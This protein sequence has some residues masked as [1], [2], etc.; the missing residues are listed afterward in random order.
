MN[1]KIAK[2]EVEAIINFQVRLRQVEED[3]F[4]EI[5]SEEKNSFN[6]DRTVNSRQ[7]HK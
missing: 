4:R 2:A 6:N 1:N 7:G 3:Y 5:E